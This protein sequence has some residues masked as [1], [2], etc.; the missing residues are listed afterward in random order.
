MRWQDF[1]AG[2][3]GAARVASLQKAVQKMKSL[4]SADPQSADFRRSWAYWANIHGYYGGESPD[5]TVQQQIAWLNQNG[6][7]QYVP[8]YTGIVDQTP[9]DSTATTTWATCQHGGPPGSFFGWHRIYVYY[10]EQ[11]LRWAAEDPNLRLPYWDYTDP[12]QLALPTPYQSTTAVFYDARRDPQ[13]N[14]GAAT[15]SSVRTN[16]DN[17]L[18]VSNFFSYE[19]RIENGVHGYVH[20]TVGPTCPV[21]HMGDVPVAGNDPVFYS[22]HANVDRLWACWQNLYP[23]PPGSWQDQAFSFPDASGTLQTNTIQEFLDSTPWGYTYDNVSNCKRTPVTEEVA[24]APGLAGEQGAKRAAN[25]AVKSK[26]AIKQPLT[27]INLG[28]RKATVQNAL[29]ALVPAERVELVLRDVAAESPPGVLFDVFLAKKGDK[30][31]RQLVGTISWFGAFRHRHGGAESDDAD[32]GV[33][34]KTYEF[35]VTDAVR[36]LGES[37]LVVE[38][39]A[40]NGRTVVDPAKAEAERANALAAFRPAAN[41]TIGSIELRTSGSEP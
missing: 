1:S 23:T 25:L 11:V 26:I 21:A 13:I 38:I 3:D 9:P 2:P 33:P 27:Q 10:F 37:K 39:E 40:T 18:G 15:L 31:S 41:L 6:L 14:T 28:A 24:A 20:C 19:L 34:A 35:D 16:V 7:G 17:A 22:H 32:T 5:G 29:A 30:E 8:Y 4:D 36:A 12:T